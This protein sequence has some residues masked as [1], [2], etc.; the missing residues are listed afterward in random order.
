MLKL[1]KTFIS[2][3]PFL[4]FSP[5]LIFLAIINFLYERIFLNDQERIKYPST[6]SRIFMKIYS[7]FNLVVTF[8]LVYL[9]PLRNHSNGLLF[10]VLFIP[11]VGPWILFRTYVSEPFFLSI[12]PS[13]YNFWNSQTYKPLW[14]DVELNLSLEPRQIRIVDII[15]DASASQMK[16]E[17]RPANLDTET[18]DAL[19]YTW[20][21]HLILRRVITV[22]NRTFFVTDSLYRALR[23]LR[24]PNQ[25]RSIWIDALCINQRDKS[26]KGRQ[27]PLMRQIFKNA[28]RVHVWLGE[29]PDELVSAFNLVR[30]VADANPDQIHTVLEGESSDAW[31]QPLQELLHRKWWSRVWIVEEVALADDV[32]IRSGKHELRWETLS[33]FLQRSNQIPDFQ[34]EHKIM[35]FFEAIAE[36]KHSPNDPEHGLLAFAL[37][38]RHR[39]AVRQCDKLFGYGGLLTSTSSPTIEINYKKPAQ[40]VFIEF[41]ASNIVRM[42]NLSV[43]TLAE[44][45]WTGASWAVDWKQMTSS[46]WMEYS[47]VHSDVGEELEI[48]NMFWNGGLIYSDIAAIRTYNAAGGLRSSCKFEAKGWKGLI[49]NGWEAD[50]VATV[51]PIFDDYDPFFMRNFDRCKKLAGGPWTSETDGKLISFDRTMTGDAFRDDLPSDWPLLKGLD[52]KARVNA[53]TDAVDGAQGRQKTQKWQLIALCCMRRR[54]FITEQGRFGLGPANISARN[55][56]CV[57]LGS[58][59]PLI[60]A[61]LPKNEF[62]FM[63]QAYVDGIMDYNGDIRQDIEHGKLKLREFIL[64]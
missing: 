40:E 8:P 57:L 38:F 54:F 60:L 33:R 28:K 49:V 11:I 56:I 7:V 31:S 25:M 63:G 34:V 10:I 41:A 29:A 43:M 36:L 50:K 14:P 18:Y 1:L 51:G 4:L 62:R 47:P 12:V 35:E 20:G 19:S 17:I 22:N 2:Y 61:G 59:V 42:K 21:S 52:Q 6:T 3:V 5:F 30:R 16:L 46:D 9:G 48:P 13:I 27:V 15:P 32:M 64:H 55:R 58:D 37:R 26:E 39:V 44:S 23:H 53:T 45:R 24:H